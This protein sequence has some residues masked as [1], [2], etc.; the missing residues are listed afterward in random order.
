MF[1]EEESSQKMAQ[2]NDFLQFAKNSYE[3]F[4]EC[5]PE[6][7]ILRSK[8]FQSAL[9]LKQ[10][11]SPFDDG[12]PRYTNDNGNYAKYSSLYTSLKDQKS[13]HWGWNTE[14]RDE[15]DKEANVLKFVKGMDSKIQEKMSY[16]SNKMKKEILVNE[17]EDAGEEVKEQ[18]QEPYDEFKK[19]DMPP[20]NYLV[21]PEKNKKI[22]ELFEGDPFGV[23]APEFLSRRA[24]KRRKAKQEKEKPKPSIYTSYDLNKLD[25]FFKGP[26][27]FVESKKHVLDEEDP[28][29][30]AVKKIEEFNQDQQAKLKEENNEKTK[31][32]QIDRDDE[33]KQYKE[34]K[35]YI[36]LRNYNQKEDDTADRENESEGEGPP[37][38]SMIRSH[39]FDASIDLKKNS[40]FKDDINNEYN[41]DFDSP[42]QKIPWNLLKVD[43]NDVVNPNAI[44]GRVSPWA[45]EEIYQLYLQG[46]SLKEIS[47]RYG[48]LVERAKVIIWCRKTFYDEVMP[49]I[50]LLTVRLGMEREMLYNTLY[51]WIDYGLDMERMIERERGVFTSNFKIFG[52]NVDFRAYEFKDERIKNLLKNKQKKKYDIVTEKFVGKA[53]SGY[54]LK[55]WVVYRGQG[56]EK[57]NKAFKH[58]VYN[59]EAKHRY[60]NR[61]NRTYQ[62]GPRKAALGHGIH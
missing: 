18:E 55:S 28:M 16:F 8:N 57:V 1:Q 61:I 12:K 20:I 43:E 7:R 23:E 9:R 27:D 21:D 32:F 34:T 54:F 50:D 45:K 13:D 17:S 36:S 44:H 42:D 3:H 49:S 26:Y 35:D 56:T 33:N 62:K 47:Q 46:A 58:T 51:P 48:I 53:G 39:N 29:M 41:D 24:L 4:K 10:D 5:T 31:E 19:V 14:N 22:K 59:S 15:E 38:Q 60:T 6:E 2:F 40:L 30:I 37:D 25:P 52:R 11:W